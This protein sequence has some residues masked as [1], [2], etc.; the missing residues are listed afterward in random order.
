MAEGSRRRLSF[1][2]EN[3][4][5]PGTSPTTG[6]QILRVAGDGSITDA[7]QTLNSN[8]FRS[9]RGLGILRHGNTNPQLAFPFELSFGTFDSIL[10]S[11]LQGAWTSNVLKQGTTKKYHSFEEGFLDMGTPQ[12]QAIKG[13]LC[14]GLDL[15]LAPNQMATGN[16]RFIGLSV[17]AFSATAIQTTAHADPTSTPPMD[18]FTGSISEGGSAIAIV[19]GLTLNLDNGAEGLYRLLQKAP[20]RIATGRANVSGTISAFFDNATLA[21]KFINETETSLSVVITDIQTTPK[22]YTILIPKLKYTGATKTVNENNI[23]LNM[24]FQAYFDSVTGTTIQ[25]TRT[26]P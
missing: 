10:E 15:S 3:S 5:T 16:F 6:W 11:A 14:S 17:T 4:A 18:S 21:N 13:A 9:D 24:P 23:I 8:E 2:A 26:A 1:V 12:Y 22:S 20:D 7:R 19:T 25:I